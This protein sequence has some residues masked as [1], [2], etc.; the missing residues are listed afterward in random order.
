M[1]LHVKQRQVCRGERFLLAQRKK[2]KQNKQEQLQENTE[3]TTAC[4]PF[5]SDLP[6]MMK[7][8][9]HVPY[10]TWGFFDL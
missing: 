5:S 9:D 1:M 6:Q 10:S 4:L 3:N 2:K 8:I 7:D